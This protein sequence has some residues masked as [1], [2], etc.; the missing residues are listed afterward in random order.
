MLRRGAGAGIAVLT[1][2]SSLAFAQ[3]QSPPT[4]P[5]K[6]VPGAMEFK[7]MAAR[8]APTDYQAQAKVGN[9][10][11]AADFDG[12]GVPT[13]EALYNTED[14]V[15]VEVAFYGPPDAKL[16]LSVEDLSLKINDKKTPLTCQAF[17]YV[18]RNLKDP[19]WEPPD[20]DKPKEKSK[21]SLN[22]GGGGG[23]EPVVPPKMPMELRHVMEQ[24]VHKS[25]FPEGDRTLPVDGLIFFQYRGKTQS[26]KNME[27]IYQG[28]AGK[29]TIPLQP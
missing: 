18:A 3:V 10:T 27:L 13:L 21:T 22:G 8:A 20:A 9:I 16:K 28:P 7:G 4:P 17:E 25:V 26:I 19:E 2:I 12:H 6:E 11:I 1:G 14:Y 29:G 5:P 23:N 24:R 15:V